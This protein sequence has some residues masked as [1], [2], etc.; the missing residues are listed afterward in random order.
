MPR[1]PA[2]V[3]SLASFLHLSLAPAIQHLPSPSTS[4]PLFLFSVKPSSLVFWLVMCSK[5]KSCV[6]G[7]QAQV[8]D[9]ALPKVSC[10]SPSRLKNTASPFLPIFRGGTSPCQRCI[11]TEPLVAMLTIATLLDSPSRFQI[12]LFAVP[13]NSEVHKP[14]LL[15]QNHNFNASS[16]SL[17]SSL[18][19][20]FIS[21]HGYSKGVR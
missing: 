11:R 3:T 10:A 1:L 18:Y 13:V 21:L 6:Y 4:S 15:A 19:A 7:L 5:G 17:D 14:C 12:T 16:K 20:E 2:A 9:L 8:S